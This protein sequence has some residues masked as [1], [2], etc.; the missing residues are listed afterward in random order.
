[1]LP[2]LPTNK[3]IVFLDRD[4]VINKNAPPHEYITKVEDFV[5]NDGIFQVLQ[6][7]AKDG[8]EFIIVSNQ[9]GVASGKISKNDLLEIDNFLRQNF[10]QKGI[11]ILDSFYCPHDVGQCECRKPKNGLL[12]LAANKYKIDWKN[13]ILISDSV[14]D[15]EM[16]KD[17]G[18]G[19]NFLVRQNHPEDFGKIRIAFVKYAGLTA[20]GSEKLAQIIAAFLPKDRFVVDFFSCDPA[21]LLGANIS[22]LPSSQERIKF[23]EDNGVNIIKFNVGAKDLRTY[24]VD[25][26]NTDFWKVFNENNYDL[27]QTSR[28]GH[29]EYPFY[30]IHKTPIIDIINLNAGVDNQYNISRVLHLC[31]WAANR[32]TKKGG[33]GSRVRLISLPIWVPEKEFSDYKLELNLVNKFVFGFHQRPD[34]N[35]FSDMPLNAYRLI[36]N[37]N[38]AFVVLGGGDEYKKQAKELDLKN[39]YFLPATG[40]QETV[41]KFLNSLNVF[42]HGRKDGEVNSQAMAEAMYFGLPI[43]SH[44]S[45]VN[46]GHVECI[47]SAGVV[48]D[49]AEEYA[50]EMQKLLSDEGYYQEKHKAAKERFMVKYELRAQMRNI[51]NIYEEVILDPFP[52]KFIRYFYS[53]HYTQ[54]LRI[55]VAKFYLWLKYKLGVDLL[56]LRS[57]K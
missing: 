2:K 16:G 33:D 26:L 20:G 54:N 7:L 24:T 5:F 55:W 41:Y 15:I 34:N 40:D 56:A 31:N 42:A 43:I 38:T 9:R 18:I 51:I 30:K 3:K 57:R 32:W 23:L 22:Q 21:P 46:N 45:Q 37:Q 29:K 14:K 17:F 44:P 12:K 47:G 8:F 36:E 4:G 1:M 52:N 27:I 6:K 35:I 25:W 39:I 13:S 28:S 50:E 19:K 11:E 53:L 48:V 49:S 10:K